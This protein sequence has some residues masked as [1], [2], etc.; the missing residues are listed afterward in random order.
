M[1]NEQINII[2]KG[3]TILNNHSIFRLKRSKKQVLAR[4]GFF[5]IRLQAV[6]HREK[7]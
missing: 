5:P 1:A 4:I 7:A 6:I 2:G 3:I